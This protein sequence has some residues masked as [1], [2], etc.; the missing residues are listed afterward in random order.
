[1]V[2][3]VALVYL[4]ITD[5][6]ENTSER[7]KIYLK[8]DATVLSRNTVKTFMVKPQISDVQITYEYIRVTYGSHTRTYG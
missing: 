6:C 3:V 2:F 8:N 1:M 7:N 4:N 5:P